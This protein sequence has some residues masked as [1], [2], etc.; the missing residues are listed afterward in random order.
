MRPLRLII[1]SPTQVPHYLQIVPVSDND[2]GDFDVTI[3][4]LGPL[5]SPFCGEDDDLGVR[6]D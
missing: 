4:D 6:L 3:S 1:S 2:T 5:E